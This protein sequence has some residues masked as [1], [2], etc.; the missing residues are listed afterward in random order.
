MLAFSPLASAALADDGAGKFVD[1]SATVSAAA[2][3]SATST[4]TRPATATSACFLSVFCSAKDYDFAAADI[5]VA[6]TV[7]A[8]SRRVRT[9]DAAISCSAA[10]SQPTAERIN[11]ISATSTPACGVSAAAFGTFKGVGSVSVALAVTPDIARV[12]FVTPAQ[13]ASTLTFSASARY[14]WEDEPDTAETWTAISDQ[15]A[16]WTDVADNST[17]WTEAA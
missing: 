16:T 9:I 11:D 8:D 3:V 2:S 12:R 1:V 7:S 10:V 17:I 13:I 4:R 6:A 5:Q 14:K 15:S